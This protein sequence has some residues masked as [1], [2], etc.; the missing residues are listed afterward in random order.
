MDSAH[1]HRYERTDLEQLGAQRLGLRAGHLRSREANPAHRHDQQVR[2]HREPLP[3]GISA[4]RVTARAIAE[5]VELLLLDPVFHLS[6]RAVQ[7][8]VEVP[9][10]ELAGRQRRHD[11]P[12]V[13]ALLEVLGLANDSARARPRLERLVA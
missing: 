11:E 12:R 10:L 13:L 6:A 5:Q 3:D 4:E 9:L 7:L 2:G 1:T 8:L